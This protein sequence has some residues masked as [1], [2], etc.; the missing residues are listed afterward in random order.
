[1]EASFEIGINKSPFHAKRYCT[2][3]TH[4]PLMKKAIKELVENKALA[5][6][7]GDSEWKAPTLGVPK[8]NDGARIVTD[9]RRLNEAIKQNP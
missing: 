1:M 6:Y 7:S 5:E 3:V 2:P 8:N 9:F 4:T